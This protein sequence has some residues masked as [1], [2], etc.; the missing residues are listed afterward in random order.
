MAKRCGKVMKDVIWE[1]KNTNLGHRA[2]SVLR[3]ALLILQ[4]G[5]KQL[6]YYYRETGYSIYR[7]FDILLSLT[8]GQK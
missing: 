4:S 2:G 1:G 3:K 8:V 7:G 5:E 6:I